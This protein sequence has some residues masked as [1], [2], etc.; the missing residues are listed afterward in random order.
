MYKIFI[1]YT[2]TLDKTFWSC[3]NKLQENNIYTEFTTDNIDV[4]K[5]ELK[6]LSSTYGFKNIRVV[7]DVTYDID[8]NLSNNTT[9]DNTKL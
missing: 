5:E 9:I 4:L 8:I 7:N 3:Y 1:K 6:F 2:S